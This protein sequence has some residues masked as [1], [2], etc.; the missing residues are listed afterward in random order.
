MR[1]KNY[2]FGKCL[3]PL[4]VSLVVAIGAALSIAPAAQAQKRLAPDASPDDIFLALRQAAASDNGALAQEL[5]G[6]LSGYDLPSYV[7][8][9]RLKP[10]VRDYSA[11]EQEIRDFMTR[12]EG[13]ALVDRLRNDWLLALGKTGNWALFD[14]QYP[15]FILDDDVQVKCFALNSRALKGAN[16]ADEARALLVSPKDYGQGCSDL[17]ATLAQNGQF[18]DADVWFQ[19]RQ[20]AENGN[21]TVARRA[22]VLVDNGDVTVQQ[23]MDKPALMLAKGPGSGVA[24]HQLYIIALGRVARSNP[25][26]AAT[27]LS[28]R[29]R[30][31]TAQEV[32]QGWAQIALAASYKLAPEAMD[33]WRKTRDALLTQDALQWKV[34]MALRAGDWKTVRTTIESMPAALRNDITWTYWLG[35]AL[36]ED[37]QNDAA[38]RLFESISANFSF[39]GQL[40]LE[41]LGQKITIP[42]GPMPPTA[43]EIALYSQN[44][45]FQ[46]SLRFYQLNLRFEAIREWN[47]ELRKMTDRQ[48]LAA[49]EYAR[50][51]DVLDRMVNTSDR[52]RAE[53]DFTQRF[54]AP[55]LGEMNAATRPLGMENA[56]IY[57]LI[58]QESRFIKS[59]RSHVGASGLMQLMPATAKFVAKKIGMT[60][61]TADQVNDINTNLLLGTSY[62][63]MVLNNLDGSETLATA[64][65]NAGPGRPRTWRATLPRTVE[66]AIFAETIPFNE[67][68]GYVK[69]VMSNATYYAAMFEN[70]PQSL[71]Q[72]MGMVA[73]NSNVATDL[74]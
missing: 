60:E 46:R 27:Y 11:S 68:R 32:A 24:N 57:G 14:E 69:N 15:K 50:Q 16:V 6:R 64:G 40:A 51:S 43:G 44:A 13:Q 28:D 56:W 62:L 41:E 8:Y 38:R 53:F 2:L 58:R 66:G 59:A 71:K 19:I 33:Y 65:Y 9:Y 22:A 5:A 55:H 67:T 31:M 12:Y 20:A 23:V 25:A 37:G 54:P 70:R 49:A 45:G 34:R 35:R 1:L 52:T 73:P 17:I 7:D 48:L 61:F 39:Y 18:T 72:R 30:Q 42:P 47:W 29:A 3:R 36:K 21:T 74:P 63:S 4:A 26:Q 10:R